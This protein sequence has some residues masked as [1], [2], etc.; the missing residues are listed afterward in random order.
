MQGNDMATSSTIMWLVPSG[1]QEKNTHENTDNLKICKTTICGTEGEKHT[2]IYSQPENMQN[3]YLWYRRR[4][5]TYENTDHLKIC[6]TTNWGTEG[7]CLNWFVVSQLPKSDSCAGLF[8]QLDN[9][10]TK[11]QHSAFLDENISLLRQRQHNLL[12]LVGFFSCRRKKAGSAFL[13]QLCIKV[14][15]KTLQ[16]HL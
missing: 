10:E 8:W 4:K 15:S 5:N 9:M 7:Y 13:N 16:D 14:H 11:L 12:P 3:N 6:T 1:T 2:W